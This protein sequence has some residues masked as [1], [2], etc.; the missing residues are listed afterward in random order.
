MTYFIASDGTK[1][2]STVSTGTGKLLEYKPGNHPDIKTMCRPETGNFMHYHAYTI[3]GGRGDVKNYMVIGKRGGIE[4]E[5]FLD[6][7]PSQY[8][9]DQLRNSLINPTGEAV[10]VCWYKDNRFVW[11][12]FGAG[13][14][15][16]KPQSTRVKTNPDGSLKIKHIDN[17]SYVGW[18]SSMDFVEPDGLRRS[19]M[20]R[21]VSELIAEGRVVYFY[22]FFGTLDKSGRSIGTLAD[23]L[24]PVWDHSDFPC[25]NG[26]P[27][28]ALPYFKGY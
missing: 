22:Q 12:V 19:D 1:Y 13:C 9:R 16:N 17:L 6:I 26:Q 18:P 2:I 15:T 21:P 25:N 24:C 5:W 20:G 28:F 23:V 4:E 10:K 14:N 11:G 3:S 8:A 7:Q 27:Y